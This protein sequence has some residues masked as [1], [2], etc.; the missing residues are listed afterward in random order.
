MSL[1]L[2]HVMIG[3]NAYLPRGTWHY[4]PVEAEAQVVAYA[5]AKKRVL[6]QVGNWRREIT[7]SPT[8]ASFVADCRNGK[9][10]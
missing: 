6:F 8:L 9:L 1:P 2:P 10:G 5:S 4:L 7:P 3:I